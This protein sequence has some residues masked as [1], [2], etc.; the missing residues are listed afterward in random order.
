MVLPT[1]Q[2]AAGLL[3]LVYLLSFVLFAFIRVVTGVSIQR[4]GVSGLRRIAF[5]PKDGL[6]IEIR[7]LGLTLHRP[8]FAQPTWLSVVLSEL[9]VTVDLKTLGD[10]PRKKSAWAKWANGSAEKRR[11]EKKTPDIAVDGE[12]TED[13]TDEE[14]QR[15]RTW[16]RLTNVKEHI[17]RLHRKIKWIKMVDLVATTTTLV[18]ADV[19]S[20]QV[21]SFTMAV[22]T[23]RK[24][25]DRSRLFNHHK[26][27]QNN[28]HRPAEWLF[29]VRSI[30]FTP[31]GRESVEILD[32]CTL[33]V[34]GMLY[35][36]L[37]GLRDASIALKL[38][39]LSIPYD[40]VKLCAERA[41]KCRAAAP[42]RHARSNT[43][44]GD[45]FRELGQPGSP[46]EE[47]V[48]T[49]AD[50][51][52][53]ASS[54][55]RGIQEFQFAISL[56][57]FTRRIQTGSDS[58]PPVY[59][60]A[61]MK[62]VSIDLLRLDPRSPAHLMYFSPN[63]IA[64]QALLAAISIS[65]GI[66]SGQGH[67]E[68]LLYVPMATMTLN[69]TLPSKTIQ[70]TKDKNV[71][72]RNTNILFANLV[73]TSPS[74]DLD[75]KHLPI[76]L[77]MTRTYE[78]RRKPPKLRDRKRSLVRRLL[79]KASIK[80]SIHEPVIRV[81]L[82]PTE[83]SRKD[84]DEFD[85]L[86]SS[87]SS[88]SLDMESSH[89]ADA[90]LH[91]GLSSTFRINS[92]RLYYQTASSEKHNL[93]L[94]DHVELKVQLSAS[95]DVLVVVN[96][97]LQTFSVFIVRSEISE[98]LRQIVAQVQKDVRRRRGGPR[99]KGLN[100]LRR[101][102]SWLSH[103]QL[104]GSDFNIEIAGIDPEVSKHARGIGLHLE[105]WTAEYRQSRGDD[106]E[107]RPVRRRA[108]SRT[109]NRD[110]YLL[111]PTTPSSPKSPR[112]PAGD[113]TDGRRLAVHWQG[114]EGFVLEAD[115]QWEADPFLGVP[116]ME[117][118]WST[119]TDKQ[120]PVF[121]IHSFCQ[122]LFFHYSL[123]RHFAVG[124]AT[125]VLKHSFNVAFTSQEEPVPVSP[126]ASRHLA[127][128]SMDIDDLDPETG[129]KRE[130]LTLDIKANFVQFK[131]DMPADPPLM[132]HVYGLEA[133]RHRWT[134]PF[135]RSRL[136]RLYAECPHVKR[137][138]S[139]IVSVKS[140]RMD[141]RKSKRRYGNTITED[142]S[143]DLV[144]DAIRIAVPHQLVMHRIFD[145]IVNVTK[146]IQ[147]L[148]FRFQTGSNR[149]VLNKEPEGP[150][151]VPKISLRSR[152]V[153]FEIE[154]GSFE[155]K[156]GVV[157]RYGLME[158]K[159]RLAREQAFELKVKKLHQEE[160]RRGNSRQRARSAHTHRGRSKVRKK[161]PVLRSKSE[162]LSDPESP[163][164]V[165][166]RGSDHPMRYDKD[167]YTGLSSKARTSIEEARERLNRLNAQTWRKR[168]DHA[169]TCQTRSMNDIRSI[170]WGLD[171][172]PDDAYSKETIMA[173]PH[174]PALGSLIVSDLDLTI[175]K[176]SFPLSEYPRFLHRVGKGMPVD[177]QYSLLIPMHVQLNMGEAKIQLRDYPLP[178]LH[179]PALHPLQSSRLP[180]VS[181]KTDFVIAEEFRDIESTRVCNVVVVP[182]ESTPSG[183]KTGGFE[184][185]IRRTVAP[186]KTYSDMKIDINS[187]HPT[188]ITW[189]TSYQPA[190]QDMMQVIESF[191]K[192]A[193]DPSERVGFWD[194][195]R[196]TFH[197]RISVSWK[198][199]GDVHLILKGSRD[200]YMVTGHGAGFV[201]CWQND[202]QL[203]L[204]EDEDPRN[205]MVVKSGSY[206]L[207]IPDLGHYARQEAELEQPTTH[208]DGSSSVS[209]H[210]QLAIFKK[211]IMKLNGNV[212]WVAG[213][214]FERNLDGGGRSFKFNP[215]YDIVLK[216]P[217]YAHPKDGKE[218]DAFRGFRSH[219][220]HMSIAIAAPHDREWSVGN[221]EPSKTYNSVHLTPRFFTH[222][223]NWWS[224]FSGAMSLPIRQGSL[225]PGIEKSSKKFGRHLAT[226]KY[227]LLLSPLYMSHVYKHKDAEDYGR[228]DVAATGLKARLDS[229]MLDLHQRREEF[230]TIVQAPKAQEDSKQNQTTGMRINQVQLDL[231]R[232]DVR[233]VSARIGGTGE[234]DVENANDETIA[235]YNQENARADLS[236][237]TIPDNDWGWVDMDDF[238][239]LGWVLPSEHN[240]ETQILPL[241][242]APRFTY[243]RQTDHADNIS[244]DPHRTSPF[245]KEP[246]HHC[247]MSARNDPRRVQCYLIEQRIQRVKEQT[248]HNE[249]AIG[250]QELKIIREPENSEELRHQLTTL[251]NH[252]EFLRRKMNF[253]QAM[254][255]SL[256]ERLKSADKHAVPNGEAEGEDEYYE[257]RE[258]YGAGDEGGTKT[259]EGAQHADF[260]SDF[261]NRFIIH[262]VHLKWNNSL[263]NIILRY[264][265]QVSQRRGFVYYMS[266][267][268]VKFILDIV[269][270][271][272]K[273]RKSSSTPGAEHRPME[274]QEDEED[275]IESQIQQLLSDGKKFIE[276][277]NAEQEQNKSSAPNN[278][279]DDVS[280]DYLA[281]NAYIVRLI[282]PQIQ[283]QSEKNTKAAVLVTAKG[284][285]LKV[286]QIMDKDRVMDDVSGLVQRRF[287]ASMDSLQIFVT[288]S[289]IFGSGDIH[290][291]SGSTY[292]APAGTAWPPWVP[293]E[294]MFDFKTHPYGFQRV[295]ERTSASMRLDK[296][297]PLR[298]KYNDDV[299]GGDSASRRKSMESRIDHIW[300]DFPH[301]RALCNSRQYYAMYIIVIDLLLY[302]EP[303]EKTRNERLEKIM[304]ASDF[305]NLSG[306][307]DL[308]IGLQERI[309]QLE[310]IK[311]VFQI[312]EKFLDKKGWSDRIEV[313]KDL[314]VFEDE[315]FFVMKAI[316]T[317]QRRY[318]DRA[319][320]K[321]LTG[322]LRW[323]ITASEIVWHLLQE[324]QTSLAE[325]QIKNAL[326]DRTDNNDGSNLNSVEIEHIVGLNLMPNA[327]YPKMISPYLE[328]SR[329]KTSDGQDSL[330][331][332]M[333]RVHWVM[334][335]A[336][337]GIPVVDH[338]EINLFPLKVAL[339][340]QIG[341]KL[342][343]YIF[344][345][346][347][348][349]SGENGN[350]TF[351]PLLVKHIALDDD[352]DDDIGNLSSTDTPT[353]QLPT[354][355]EDVE[356]LKL[357]LTP[358]L[359][360]PT[361]QP[362]TEQRSSKTRPNLH[363]LRLFRETQSR[364]ATEM[365]RTLHPSSA[366]STP[367]NSSTNVSRPGTAVS[368]T[369]SSFSVSTAES[370]RTTRRFALH[371]S[372][373]GDKKA[374][375]QKERNDD[376]TQMMSRASNYMTL[377]YARIP[378]LILCLSYKGKGN[379]NFEDIHDLVFKLPT[380][381]YRNKTCS[382]LDLVLQLKRDVIRA[383]I[384]HAGAIVGNK[385]SHHRPSKHTQS[386][387][388]QIANSSS[389]MS[390][391]PDLSGTDS[392]SI[393]D[394]SP[395]ESDSNASGELPGRRSFASGRAPSTFSALS[396]HSE[397]TSMRSSRSNTR[398]ATE[399]GSILGSSWHDTQGLGIEVEDGRTFADELSRVDQTEPGHAGVIGSLSRHVTQ[400][401]PFGSHRMK[402]R[403]RERLGSRGGDGSSVKTA[404]DEDDA[405]S[406][407]K[408]SK[409]GKL[410]GRSS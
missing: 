62:E 404:E 120:G 166:R 263:R 243:F 63:D 390:T 50:S 43:S 180:S 355:G 216:H 129:L 6:R 86:I 280:L 253:L 381:E 402:D 229:F 53:F 158:Q 350:G 47:I 342:F 15:S 275:T 56:F 221:L 267:R 217:K 20:L 378:S 214:V 211:T 164:S 190:I 145:N 380:L 141:Y 251:Q 354:N 273:L 92:Q 291:Y 106:S 376:L 285:Q 165:R 153:L 100:F 59:L 177:M 266:R 220:I 200:P 175:D 131:G 130:I 199:D 310:E 249:R 311:S 347:K 255:Q 144:A 193:I 286:I 154:D 320:A 201:M 79:P 140:L 48:R 54:I 293:F 254:H 360:L 169:L 205:F 225:W 359:H 55:L 196:L 246:T 395:G 45:A 294:V 18:I 66:D 132:V 197:S 367:G 206:V 87:S 406:H 231:I 215:H 228:G 30:L 27:K 31:E 83:P 198:G 248:S 188:R 326:F 8:T 19:G 383:L 336:I 33:N 203:T 349:K 245:G 84:S 99:K 12:D 377:A 334:L 13:T 58:D 189:G 219:H 356:G 357:R 2:L 242:F 289:K 237:F 265:H 305:S 301:I 405:A 324:G 362:K 375:T 32:Q 72:E 368:R 156:L 366:M 85:L 252:S 123:Y 408:K 344:P 187:S 7:G 321:E 146:T 139:R 297:N 60:N 115:E 281:Q 136:V 11:D 148:H 52:E 70:F 162:D 185:D 125:M 335:E 307:P 232:T 316:T 403:E 171:E 42:I 287:T 278:A 102:P 230:R 34:H 135:F 38:G 29:T 257:A 339:E 409:L 353:M 134:N 122:S 298:L 57:S 94:T 277:D 363:H 308:V 149:Y 150:K 116:R 259:S 323:Y 364:S 268:A 103:V 112:K 274:P 327:I 338:F 341:K 117:V 159:Q 181:L 74:I 304:L 178:L 192:P 155:W 272:D 109:I 351:S 9:T 284:M 191:T 5:A 210:K 147:Q 97:N 226:I 331:T 64:H 233:A 343:E 80:L 322:T 202:V 35:K 184:V 21:G 174:R 348:D 23:R 152:A 133:G 270:E 325:F 392:A 256:I 330:E 14:G 332:K 65:V 16:E 124:V 207:A 76:L 234:D 172:V 292:G 126:G 401:T 396:E 194:K 369:N 17:K 361:H 4:L 61:S 40:E 394:H 328:A 3:L 96:G 313:E 137:V 143:F 315:L 365:R 25:V 340:W 295:V 224:M 91:Y 98:G 88:V 161:E 186:V 264:I 127:I 78:T 258:D 26:P 213:L 168:I 391:S 108:A 101:L 389:I 244:G 176:P 388:R 393:R 151:H 384:S 104:Q 90:E 269:E 111:R 371:R 386:R 89:A 173:I 67:P 387:L 236:K 22:D 138:W 346:I 163:D 223:Y 306:A 373:T 241:A 68:R 170:F 299:S 235:D 39:R 352:D 121:H 282:A 208:F 227:N 1:V 209:S 75:P 93:L 204:A 407:K 247:V 345:G 73:I 105:S 333:L 240:P 317:A 279:G 329:P 238:V 114:F 302:N 271:Q 37:D 260:I 379:R 36:E 314:A 372:G 319:Q 288:N 262:N 385:F 400:L 24:T 283:L 410:L 179:F 41:R 167:G 46:E 28:E 51:R 318:D 160:E 113:P 157:Y 309:R 374:G 49:V 81:T 296:Y 182:E 250:D 398:P 261:N 118:A 218:Y 95:P 399:N 183:A 212:R 222:F 300:V 370:D 195:I 69:T 44:L 119:S 312:N 82:P 10:K 107:A 128:P 358:T 276:A 303:L 71:A 290:M 110:E 77:A 382:N 337:A 142:K 397:S 239:E